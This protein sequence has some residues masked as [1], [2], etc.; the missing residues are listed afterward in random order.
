MIY[1]FNDLNAETLL[2]FVA[3]TFFGLAG[4]I[5]GYFAFNMT[6]QANHI[7]GKWFWRL[8]Y[9]SM[10]VLAIVFFKYGIIGIRTW[11]M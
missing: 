10:A 1:Q 4:V 3:T 8:T 2:I 6:K 11:A 5:C 7:W 9:V